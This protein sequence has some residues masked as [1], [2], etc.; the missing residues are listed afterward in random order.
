MKVMIWNIWINV[1]MKIDDEY[2][3]IMNNIDE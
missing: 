1:M 3:M 2:T